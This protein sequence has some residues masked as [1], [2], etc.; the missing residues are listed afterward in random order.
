MTGNGPRVAEIMGFRFLGVYN[1]LL[2]ASRPVIA[3]VINCSVRLTT[4][5]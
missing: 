2:I 5:V 3:V 4:V 1:G